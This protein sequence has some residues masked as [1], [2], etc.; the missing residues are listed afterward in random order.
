M[1][2]KCH[3]NGDKFA[4]LPRKRALLTRKLV[5]L[6]G[7]RTSQY[8]NPMT[9]FDSLQTL[10][11]DGLMDPGAEVTENNRNLFMYLLIKVPISCFIYAWIESLIICAS[12]APGQGSLLAVPYWMEMHTTIYLLVLGMLVHSPF[13]IT[14]KLFVCC[15]LAPALSI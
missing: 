15:I 14:E 5:I 3:S 1:H 6:T 4:S 9:A 7:L 12:N 11:D 10:V 8:T 13:Q 2:D